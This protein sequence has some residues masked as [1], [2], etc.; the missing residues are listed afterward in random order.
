MVLFSNNLVIEWGKVAAINS[1]IQTLTLPIRLNKVL[2]PT[3]TLYGSKM[4]NTMTN[5]IWTN[6]DNTTITFYAGAIC[7]S[8]IMVLGY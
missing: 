1:G 2:V 4:S 6:F 3:L 8:I 7:D 5:P